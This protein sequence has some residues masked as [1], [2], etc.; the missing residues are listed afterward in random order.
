MLIISC[1]IS[2]LI[3]HTIYKFCLEGV[4]SMSTENK[5]KKQ[6]TIYNQGFCDGYKDG[7]ID[8]IQRVHD[9]EIGVT[10]EIIDSAPSEGDLPETKNDSSSSNKPSGGG[11]LKGIVR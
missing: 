11:Y 2:A 10:E 8:A 6:P 5:T 3:I 9:K 7:Y 4:I 1:F